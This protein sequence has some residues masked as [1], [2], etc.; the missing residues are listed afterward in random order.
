[1]LFYIVVASG[2]FGLV[3]QQFVPTMMTARV[4]L[5]T[6]HSQIGHVAEELAV[7]AYEI[8][9]S[10]AG[11]MPEAA[12]EQAALAAE[13]ALLRARPGNWKQVRRL[14][15]AAESTAGAPLRAFYL[16]EIRP[17]LRRSKGSAA[18]PPDFTQLRLQAP[19]EWRSQ[20]EKLYQIVD[21]SRQLWV[22]LKLHGM[23]HNW[24][25]VHAPLSFAMF[26][27]VAFHIFFALRY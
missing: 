7:D 5:E 14:P 25:F 17:Y 21:E 12:E 23:L 22:Q 10:L 19:E 13:E 16:S 1:V 11:G 3:L 20:V 4:P 27:L 26:V 6:I 18:S 9:A 8:V 15:P 2:L 24:L